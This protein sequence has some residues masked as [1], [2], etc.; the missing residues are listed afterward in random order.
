MTCQSAP[1]PGSLLDTETIWQRLLAPASQL[2]ATV[3]AR[4][5]AT[6]LLFGGH[7]ARGLALSCVMVG[8]V[9]S[10]T[11]TLAWHDAEASRESVLLS[12]TPF[13]PKP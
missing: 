13:E 11:L 7:S 12:V 10:T 3:A 4:L 6:S 1:V 9:W 5:T 2:S 8:A